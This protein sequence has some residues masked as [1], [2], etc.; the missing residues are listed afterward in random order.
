VIGFSTGTARVESDNS[1]N[2]VL[3]CRNTPIALKPIAY[4]CKRPLTTA[5]RDHNEKK[6]AGAD[7]QRVAIRDENKA[8]TTELGRRE[9][10]RILIEGWSYRVAPE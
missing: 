1:L 3:S 5:I 2:S 9:Q 4:E 10:A 6:C 7:V 8:Q